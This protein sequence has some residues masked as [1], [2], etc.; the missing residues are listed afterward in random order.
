MP[1]KPAAEAIEAFVRKQDAATLA[2]VLLELA[3]EHAAVR[4]RL[5]RLK[6]SNQ[7]KSLAAGFRKTLTAWQRPA[8]YLGYAHAREFGRELEAWLGQIE[9]ELMPQDPAAAL[10][11]AEAFIEADEVFFNRIDDSDGAVGEA[12][13]AGCR[14]WLTAAS[15][16][17]TPADQW[18]VRLAALVAADEYG[19]REELLRCANLLLGDEALRAMVSMYE[20]QID[21]A[22]SQSVPTSGRNNWPA[23]KASAALSLLSEALKDPDVLVR[24]V[25]KHSPEPNPAQKEGLVQAFL[26]HQRPEGALAWLDGSWA[27]LE[28]SRERLHAEVLKRLGR[29]EE[30]S[31]IRQRIFEATLAVHDL[32]TWL[33]TL[34]P[35][36]HAAATEH[37]AVL[38]AKHADPA[39]AASLLIDIDD[40]AGAEATLVAA[41]QRIRGGDYA[42]LVPLAAQLEAR[43]CWTGATVVYRALLEAILE[44]AYTPAYRHGARYWSRLQA[45][46]QKCAGLLP[47]ETPEVFE[48]RIRQQHGRKSSFWAKV[49]EGRS[50]TADETLTASRSAD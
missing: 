34:P 42:A 46:A 24:S 6:R 13:R 19:A 12:V 5:V 16:C 43:E 31:A 44:R 2:A 17:E 4:D 50:E 32:H 30:A 14:L 28:P 37:A 22:L 35:A 23:A 48:A 47:L 11:L 1:G 38:A 15:H 49:N 7:P 26:E 41:P 3:E 33:E 9:R 27:H 29:T 21:A 40:D 8:K 18:P 36:E 39:V 10:V 20:D 45:L 25:L